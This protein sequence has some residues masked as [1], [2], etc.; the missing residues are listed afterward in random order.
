[1][2]ATLTVSDVAQ[3]LQMSKT[4]IYKLAESGKLPSIKIGSSLRFTEDQITQFLS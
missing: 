1:M 2:K 3:M 4:S